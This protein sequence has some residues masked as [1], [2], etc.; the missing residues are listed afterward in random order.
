LNPKPNLETL[1]FIIFAKTK[2][3]CETCGCN[4]NKGYTINHPDDHH[5]H[6]FDDQHNPHDHSHEHP[7]SHDREHNHS[8][9][10]K[11]IKIEQDVLQKNN[12]IAER[13][14]GFFEAKNILSLNLVSSPGSGKTT[15]LERTIREL[16]GTK[17]SVIEGDQQTSLDAE[18]IRE[19]GASVL[20]INTGSGCHLDAGMVNNAVKKLNPPENSVVMIENVGNLVCPALFDL[21]ESFR[22]L[23]ISV[24]EGEDKPLKYPFMFRSSQLCL[25]NK[26]DLLPYT[27]LNINE[28][29]DNAVKINP[30]LSFIELSAK[31]GEGFSQWIN[32]LKS[33]F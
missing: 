27:G 20:Q 6:H 12:L 33:H 8:H 11:T 3:M 19:T 4:E 13:N 10:S 18:R 2:K 16:S 25:I 17:I 7:H 22:I 14:R 31:T 23:V 29:K 24:T 15:L 9:T 30:G 5:H 26:I 21:G 28:L 32:W 1:N